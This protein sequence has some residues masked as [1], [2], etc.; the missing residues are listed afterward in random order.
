MLE[1]KHD[2][3]IKQQ[4]N[5]NIAF[6]EEHL[7]DG[8]RD[9]NGKL[10]PLDPSSGFASNSHGTLG[11]LVLWLSCAQPGAGLDCLEGPI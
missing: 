9:M 3:F 1:A 11:P 2:P 5:E 4:M 7:C 10:G 6:G 8:R